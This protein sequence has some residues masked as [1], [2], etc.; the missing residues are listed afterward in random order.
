MEKIIQ[1][2]LW[3]NVIYPKFTGKDVLPLEFNF[4]D[5]ETNKELG[6]NTLV[7]KLGA[8]Y[9]KI[10]C[11]PPKARS[12]LENIFSAVLYHSCDRALGNEK[13]FRK[14]IAELKYLE[15]EGVRIVLPDGTVKRV[16]FALSLVTGD[17]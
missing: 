10:G 13:V 14:V 11:L 5:Y 17:N 15:E 4:D 8:G 1:G 12:L 7:H 9:V 16:Y 3:K 2:D 6:T